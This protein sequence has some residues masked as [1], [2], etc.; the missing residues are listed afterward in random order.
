MQGIA[1]AYSACLP[2]I[3]FYGPTY[4]SP[5]IHHVARFATQ[6]LQQERAAVSIPILEPQPEKLEKGLQIKI[7]KPD[8][9][10]NSQWS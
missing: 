6:A 1:Q 4:F 9:A 3:R 7:K 10:V 5:I 8:L 2:L